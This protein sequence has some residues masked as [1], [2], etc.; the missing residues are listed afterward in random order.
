MVGIPLVSKKSNG[1]NGLSSCFPIW[2]RVMRHILTWVVFIIGDQRTL[3]LLK[4]WIVASK[5]LLFRPSTTEIVNGKKVHTSQRGFLEERLMTSRNGY[6][7]DD[8]KRGSEFSWLVNALRV[9]L[10]FSTRNFFS[11][12]N[13]DQKAKGGGSITWK[14]LW[15]HGRHLRPLRSCWWSN[16]ASKR[17]F[18]RTPT[19][20][21]AW[22]GSWPAILRS[23]HRIWFEF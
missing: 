21:L 8:V 5:A 18:H 1:R 9:G 14:W 17:D 12:N 16:V 3:A 13:T 7:R 11:Q 2:N 15:L 19:G 22:E 23:K 6:F 20:A 4:C 10:D